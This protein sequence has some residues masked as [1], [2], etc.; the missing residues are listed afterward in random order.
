MSYNLFFTPCEENIENTTPNIYICVSYL[1]WCLVFFGGAIRQH[2]PVG[3]TE[4]DLKPQLETKQSNPCFTSIGHS[5]CQVCMFPLFGKLTTLWQQCSFF[6][7]RWISIYR[8]PILSSGSKGTMNR[9]RKIDLLAGALYDA[10]IKDDGGE[11][12][13][14]T[15]EIVSAT[16]LRVHKTRDAFAVFMAATSGSEETRFWTKA[17]IRD[18][19][20]KMMKERGLEVPRTSGF[21][22]SEWLKDQVARIHDL[23]QRARRNAWK[24]DNWQT[25]PYDPMQDRANIEQC[26]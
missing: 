19:V 10:F 1:E 12:L 2:Y 24:M 18:A 25:L 11:Y 21:V 16:T 7:Q 17:A 14:T 23:T 5:R 26:S 13:A 20:T 9:N 8:S 6:F 15:G 3:I 22:W 4:V